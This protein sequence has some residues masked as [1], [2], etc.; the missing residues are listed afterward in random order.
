MQS[1]K[2][3]LKSKR[4]DQIKVGDWVIF[5]PILGTASQITNIKDILSSEEGMNR[6]GLDTDG[7][8]DNSGWEPWRMFTAIETN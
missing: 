3:Q 5:M 7:L 6:V 2:M 4:A 1:Q 8:V